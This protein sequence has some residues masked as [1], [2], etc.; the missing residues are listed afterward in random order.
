MSFGLALSVGHESDAEYLDLEL[1]EPTDPA[2][3]VGPLTAALPEGMASAGPSTRRPGP[4]APGG[5]DGGR[6][7]GD[8]RRRGRDLPDPAA[9]QGSIAG[10]S[11]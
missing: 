2:A 6:V 3:L 8:G 9:V 11:R 5:G 1:R 4:L 10:C 7:H